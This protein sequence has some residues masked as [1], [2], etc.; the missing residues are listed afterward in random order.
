[1]PLIQD[2]TQRVNER[3]RRCRS[4]AVRWTGDDIIHCSRCHV[5]W[6]SWELFRAHQ[7]K[8]GGC[9]KPSW[10]DAPPVESIE[11]VFREKMEP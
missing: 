3:V 9:L 10:M 7:R 5:S 4:C 2:P 1:M 11:G 8:H 6:S